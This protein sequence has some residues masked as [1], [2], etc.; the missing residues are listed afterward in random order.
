MEPKKSNFPKT[1]SY[2]KQ[3]N[4]IEK[5]TKTKYENDNIND[6]KSDSHVFPFFSVVIHD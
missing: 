2:Q 3:A 4:K 1:G 6:N 5:E